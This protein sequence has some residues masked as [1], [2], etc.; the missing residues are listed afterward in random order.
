MCIMPTIT[1][2]KM[3]SK[4]I[5]RNILVMVEQN[6][7]LTISTFIAF[8]RQEFGYT[9]TYHNAWLAKQLALEKVYGNWEELY[10][11]LP[12]YLQALKL[13]VLGTIVRIQTILTLDKLNQFQTRSYSID[14]F[15]HLRHTLMCLHVVNPLCKS[16]EHGYMEDT[17]GHY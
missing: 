10:N 2:N 15:G 5:G 17:K 16:M 11:I 12:K 13:F 7:Q 9:I 8:I 3:D 4:L 6:E 1:H 14:F